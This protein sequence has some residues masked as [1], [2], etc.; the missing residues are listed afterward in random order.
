[1]YRFTTKDGQ[2]A[3][4]DPNTVRA[5]V[6]SGRTTGYVKLVLDGGHAV[7]VAGETEALYRILN[8]Y[9]LHPV[10]P[11]AQAVSEMHGSMDELKAAHAEARAVS[12]EIERENRRANLLAQMPEEQN[13]TDNE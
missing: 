12:Q 13:H 9:R 2:Y 6:P 5:I 1:M 8:Q 10:D 11:L 3:R 7:T 4:V